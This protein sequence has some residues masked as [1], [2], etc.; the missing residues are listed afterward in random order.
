MDYFEKLMN[1]LSKVENH[2]ESLII[3]SGLMLFSLV[4][5]FAG[6]PPF[7]HCSCSTLGLC[8]LESRSSVSKASLFWIAVEIVT[9]AVFFI[10]WAASGDLGLSL[11]V[12]FFGIALFLFLHE[13]SS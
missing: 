13:I 12:L 8:L 1:R 6:F 4:F 5:I 7:N 10:V 3:G 2:T 11:L 9:L